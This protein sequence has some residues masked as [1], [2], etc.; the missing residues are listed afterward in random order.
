MKDESARP[1]SRGWIWFFVIL[2]VLAIAAI[3]GNIVYNLWQQLKPEQL[4]TARA[5][6]DA[7]KPSNYDMEYT[8][9][10]ATPGTFTVEVRDGKIVSAAR[11]GQ[12][13]DERLYGYYDMNGLFNSIDQFMEIDQKPGAPRTFTKATFDASDGHVIRYIRRV[14]G[15][16]ERLEI[17]VKLRSGENVRKPLADGAPSGDNR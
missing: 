3:T 9:A 6:W 5:L 2:S 15:T 13:L 10:G 12:P 1:R 4:A 16:N 8:Q 17:N 11:D 7:K 14:M